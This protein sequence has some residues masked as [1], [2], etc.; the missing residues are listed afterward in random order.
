MVWIHGDGAIGSGDQFDPTRLAVDGDVVVITFNYRLGVFG[1]FG[2]P[3]LEDSGTIGLQDQRAVLHWVQRNAAAFGGDPG[4]VTLFGVSYGATATSAHLMSS[5]RRA[6]CSTKV[7]MQSGFT[8]MDM[9]AGL[10]YPGSPHLPLVRLD[11]PPPSAQAQGI[12][13]SRSNSGART[14]RGTR[15]LRKVPVAKILAV[16]Q[17]MNIFQPVRPRQ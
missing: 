4:N 16:P 1:G 10:A 13:C 15:R 14:L 9:P 7:I 6:A 17:V 8:L 5:R 11:R 2:L 3:G 12:R